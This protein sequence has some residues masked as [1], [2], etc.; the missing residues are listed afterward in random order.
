MNGDLQNIYEIVLSSK[1]HVE[2]DTSGSET[3]ET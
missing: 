3:A 1:F 2:F